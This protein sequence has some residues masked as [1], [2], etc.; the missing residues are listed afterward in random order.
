MVTGQNLILRERLS[1]RFRSAFSVVPSRRSCPRAPENPACGK[2][3][4]HSEAGSRRAEAG[5]RAGGRTGA[6]PCARPSASRARRGRR[7]VEA[8]GA[9][10]DWLFG[11]RM[12]IE[13]P[14]RPAS[15]KRGAS[16]CPVDW[17][18]GA[19]H[20]IAWHGR[21]RRRPPRRQEDGRSA[22]CVSPESPRA[23]CVRAGCSA[24]RGGSG[25]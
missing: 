2:Q 13:A 15:A 19:V 16:K 24:A 22:A 10:A 12:L 11:E 3:C 23:R 5:S 9:S 7:C 14:V 8:G 17:G 21:G 20:G 4:R 1:R 25:G 6:R 18:V